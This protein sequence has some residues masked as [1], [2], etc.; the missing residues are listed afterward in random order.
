MGERLDAE[1][2]RE[3]MARYFDLARVAIERHGGT[4]EKF[5][6]DA[7]MAAFGIPRMREDDPLRAVRAAIDI[8][9]SLRAISN[10]LIAYYGSGLDVRTGVNTGEV[11]AAD[12]TGRQV[13]A[14][15][16]AVNV[17]ARLEQAAPPGE[18]LIGPETY[19][20]VR[21]A[22][23]VK[24]MESLR[25]KG[26]AE[27]LPAFRLISV[28]ATAPGLRRRL[29]VP[30]VG[31]EGELAT[32]ESAFD[33]AVAGGGAE[34]LTMIGEPGV[35]KTRL[36]AGLVERLP[37]R[38]MTLEGRCLPYGEGTGL[39][40]IE[41]ALKGAAGVAADD[42]D[43]VA[44][45]KLTALV[46]GAGDVLDSDA[47]FAALGLS[48][49]RVDEA[50]ILRAFR[51]FF[52]HLVG[53]NPAVLVL[54]DVH[55][56]E[57]ELLEIVT[58]L[59]GSVSGAGL[60]ILCLSR[61]PVAP[62][63]ALGDQLGLE[64]LS[65]EAA[66]T[67]IEV[68][69][70][71]GE[72][73]DTLREELLDRSGGNALF[74]EETLRLLLDRG[75][76]VR[77][78]GRWTLI[79]GVEA[80][81]L[82]PTVEAVLGARIDD[83]VPAERSTIEAA[84]VSGEIFWRG[85]IKSIS[86]DGAVRDLDS[87]LGSLL[88]S[89]LIQRVDST[90]P[91][92]DEF[93]FGHGLIREVAY[94]STT[95][96]RRSQLHEG[97]ARWISARTIGRAGEHH[98]ITGYHLE[99]AFNLRIQLG[100][101]DERALAIAREGATHLINGARQALIRDN[102]RAAC[103]LFER[104]A[105]L[106]ADEDPERPEVQVSLGEALVAAGRH[107]EA[108]GVLEPMLTPAP[109]LSDE[110]H[111]RALVQGAWI[112]FLSDFDAHSALA[113]E[114]SEAALTIFRKRSDH[115][116]AAEALMTQGFAESVRGQLAR[117]QNLL[118]EALSEAEDSRDHRQQARIRGLLDGCLLLGPTRRDRAVVSIRETLE[119]AREQGDRHI[120]V[121]SS[122]TN[123]AWL[124]TI[125]GEIEEARP[126]LDEA[127]ETLEE[128]GD[129]FWVVLADQWTGECELLAENYEVAE[130]N[131]RRAHEALTA[132]GDRLHAATSGALLALAL[133]RTGQREEASRLIAVARSAT[134]ENDKQGLV[135]WQ[136]SAAEM[137]LADDEPLEAE[138]RAQEAVSVTDGTDLLTLRADALLSWG[139]ALRALESFD[140]MI[141]VLGEARDAYVA[142]DSVI[143][144]REVGRLLG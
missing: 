52:D 50:E 27:P 40:P 20:R 118:V 32:L 85:A 106:L 38:T 116:G 55:W 120:L 4:V 98:V 102:A 61:E 33:R 136:I 63:A 124:R 84:A 93:Q 43:D 127:R 74:L 57:P 75:T 19:E 14:S 117:G 133:I 81:Q 6:G 70:G 88:A 140:P 87:R 62:F 60:L 25:L 94:R 66:N 8:R 76:L 139:R 105:L 7:V 53:S 72:I 28:D 100:R 142:K 89:G 121:A 49:R 112:D 9:D 37:D 45:D 104:S 141:R 13:F 99:Q 12:A 15:G 130:S 31:R 97:F 41:Q 115:G 114:R 24:R 17:A 35:G 132:A 48:E 47:L 80:L 16:D 68:V 135:Q 56:A 46:A 51:R 92:E 137:A 18:I 69:L 134:P 109:G 123:L 58:H 73:D 34:L 36:S 54:D 79:S 10:E 138:R 83:L 2:V 113:L 96:R 23:E 29:D 78:D 5:V 119:W 65:K 59:V 44:R 95:K 143:G 86:P 125:G 107:E 26:K 3:V 77:R 11:V 67:M 103:G 126:D 30:L 91:G 110:L 90:L 108:R 1:A 101:P 22:V 128:I 64:P 21:D 144:L 39:W 131:L 111:A 122:L 42:P 71:G 129:P 82:P